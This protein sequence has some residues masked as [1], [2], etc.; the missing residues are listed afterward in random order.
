MAGCV[1]R[2]GA[3]ATNVGA[4]ANCPTG[5]TAP[6]T[7]AFFVSCWY[8][9]QQCSEIYST[10]KRQHTPHAL[11]FAISV[12]RCPKANIEPRRCPENVV[13][14]AQTNLLLA[15]S[16]GTCCA[17]CR[18]IKA[19]PWLGRRHC[20][21]N[22]SSLANGRPWLGRRHCLWNASSLANGPYPTTTKKT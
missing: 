10:H 11:A 6:F 1:Q 3:P 13:F 7:R 21:W 17:E 22:A 8:P 19:R 15:K 9:N 18:D 4:N 16:I 5:K 20:L 2:V 12:L 14:H